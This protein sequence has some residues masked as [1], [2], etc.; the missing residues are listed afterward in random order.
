M[1][2]HNTTFMED[3]LSRGNL[4]DYVVKPTRDLITD[5]N[6]SNI[7][8]GVLGPS[9]ERHT[10]FSEGGPFSTTLSCLCAY[11]HFFLFW[12]AL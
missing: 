1:V 4:T 9:W 11:W 7:L 5:S 10:H 8:K 2:K 6:T 3:C 12:C